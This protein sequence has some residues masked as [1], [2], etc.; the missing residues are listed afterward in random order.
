[1]VRRGCL[2]S[3]ASTGACS[4]PVKPSTATTASTP[5]VPNPAEVRADGDK[6]ATL[7]C[8]LAGLDRPETV[9]ATMTTISAAVRAPSTL[10]VMSTRSRPSTVMTAHAP[11]A[12]SHHGAC[13]PRWAAARLAAAGAHA[14]YRATCRKL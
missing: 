12:H 10:P 13:T 2:A 4:N 8:P 6:A 11:S 14:P 3:S 5:A 1:M 9:S 7:R